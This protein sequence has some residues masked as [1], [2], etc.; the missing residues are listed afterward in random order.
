MIFI[1]GRE[2]FEN[3]VVCFEARHLK[4]TVALWINIAFVGSDNCMSV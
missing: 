1:L 4:I 3:S 2:A